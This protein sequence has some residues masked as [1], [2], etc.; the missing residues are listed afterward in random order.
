MAWM[1]PDGK[2]YKMTKTKLLMAVAV[3]TI[4]FTA[5]NDENDGAKKNAEALSLYVDSVDNLTPVYTTGYWSEIDNGYQERAMKEEKTSAALNEEDRQTAEASRTKYAALKAK[6]EANIKE[7]EA[8]NNSVPNYRIVLRNRLFGEGKVGDDMKFS[9]VNGANILSVYQNFVD[10]VADD[11]NNF[12]REDWDEI[13]V[14]YEALDTR[15]NVVEKDLA[16]RDNLKIAALK[17]RYVSI[18]ATHRGGTK[19]KENSEAKE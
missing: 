12:S 1:L 4:G 17:I 18:A 8:A 15:K 2:K 11:K 16:T 19:I 5:C 10:I 3:V 7:S 13:K 9:Y 14:L 6:Y